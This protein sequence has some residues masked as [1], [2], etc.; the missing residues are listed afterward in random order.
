MQAEKIIRYE[1]LP[2]DCF[3]HTVSDYD[4]VASISLIIKWKNNN[5]KSIVVEDVFFKLYLVYCRRVYYFLIYFFY[6]FIYFRC[7]L[8]TKIFIEYLL[9]MYVAWYCKLTAAKKSWGEKS[10]F[11]I[12]ELNHQYYCLW[13]TGLRL[14]WRMIHK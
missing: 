10:H 11:S 7:F 3:I 12:R 4:T 14:V 13:L 2:P 1:K 9:F 8:I 6:Q 5:R